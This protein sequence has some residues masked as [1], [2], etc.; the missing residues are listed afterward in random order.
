MPELADLAAAAIG[1]ARPGEAVEAYAEES[2]RTQVEAR[3]GEIEGLTSAESRGV[4]VRVIAGGRMGFS[5]A[6]DPSTEEVRQTLERARENAALATEDEHNAL[7]GAGAYEPIDGL[8]FEEQAT[9]P[10]A[11]KVALALDLERVAVSTDPAV[12]K[13]EACS[14]GDAVVSCG[15][16]GAR[17][18]GD[19]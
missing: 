13:V 2:R 5:Y 9:M 8:Y 15:E 12:R 1:G 4:G 14:F 17:G 7:P 16:P 18:H 11:D 10:P 6:A 19:R 3:R